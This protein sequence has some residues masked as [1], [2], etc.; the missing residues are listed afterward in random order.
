MAM[1]NNLCDDAL[2]KNHTPVK[3]SNFYSRIVS[4][5]PNG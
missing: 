1:V 2:A 3:I 5:A 4:E